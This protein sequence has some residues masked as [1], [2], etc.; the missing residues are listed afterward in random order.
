M[1]VRERERERES[2]RERDRQTDRQRDRE[3]DRQTEMVR[4]L[5]REGERE[6]VYDR[7]REREKKSS[8]R[9]NYGSPSLPILLLGIFMYVLSPHYETRLRIRQ[10]TTALQDIVCHLY[11]WSAL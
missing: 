3:R 2:E 11:V 9:E 10:L 5:E 6:C 8:S 1:C 7:Q 4:V